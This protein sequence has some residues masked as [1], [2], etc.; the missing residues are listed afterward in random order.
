VLSELTAHKAD[1]DARDEKG[2]TPLIIVCYDNQ[3]VAV[4]LLLENVDDVNGTDNSGINA[5]RRYKK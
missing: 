1:L 3:Y 5:R 2:Y 4:K